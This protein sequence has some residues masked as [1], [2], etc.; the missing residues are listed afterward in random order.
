[1]WQLDH[2]VDAR[3]GR[4]CT[5]RGHEL[6]NRRVGAGRGD[7]HPTVRMVPHPA[8]NTDASRGLAHEPTESDALYLANDLE[9]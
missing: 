5:R 9:M 4:A 6:R 1:V 8:S 7:L 3:A 2:P